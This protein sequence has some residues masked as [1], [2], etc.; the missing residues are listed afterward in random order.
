VQASSAATDSSGGPTTQTA[1]DAVPVKSED[2]KF[3]E[4]YAQAFT[5]SQ[6][7]VKN[8]PTAVPLQGALQASR[9]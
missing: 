8:R 2:E 3:H 6:L 7:Y 4:A 5:M 1:V 9:R